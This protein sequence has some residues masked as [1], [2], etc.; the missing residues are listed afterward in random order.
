M[1]TNTKTYKLSLPAAILININIMLGAGVFVNTVLLAQ[2]ASMYGAL[3][4]ALVGILLLPLIISFAR[5][6][7]LYEGG[8]FYE[9]GAAIHPLVG[10]ISGFSYFIAK[11]ASCALSIHVFVTIMQT[12]FP[13]FTV[14]S[15]LTLDC[16]IIALFAL[17]N[18]LNVR[19][20]QSIQY[21]FLL[22]KLIPILF[23]VLG[24]AYLITSNQLPA[25][26]WGALPWS[27][28]TQSVPFVLYAFTG[29]EACC[30]LSRNIKNADTNGPRTLLISYGFGVILVVLYQLMFSLSLGDTLAQLSSY[31]QAFP[32]LL[33]KIVS[34]SN[35]LYALFSYLLPIGVAS[36]SL[37]AAYGIM[38][39]N[40]WNMFGLASQGFI[41][42]S[43][44][45]SKLNKHKIPFVV[46]ILEGIIAASYI[47]LSQGNQVPLQQICALGMT[48]TYTISALALLV[49][50]WHIRHSFKLGSLLAL[51]SCSLLIAGLVN[52]IPHYNLWP[53]LLFSAILLGGV[54]G[55]VMRCQNLNTYKKNY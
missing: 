55:F 47:L 15:P 48:M 40:S 27:G 10:F 5:L 2:K 25:F 51:G 21:G 4:Y 24:G 29:F 36:S 50:E 43:A 19:T 20:G 53:L 12:A 46:I 1:T 14:I 8:S 30:S 38:Y 9:F 28:I 31:A 3:V 32:A 33:N 35:S 26:N 37:G 22:F 23:A 54:F 49:T 52:N 13:W 34:P 7:S 45:F 16:L 17:L 42:F 39:S 18:M 44:T 41:P 11:L 6:L